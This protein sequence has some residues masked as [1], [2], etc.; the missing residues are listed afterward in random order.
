MHSDAPA[1]SALFLDV[2]L[3][4]LATYLRM[5]GYDTAY[6][7]DRGVED[8]D[9]ILEL[10]RG[11]GR[12]LVTRDEELAARR[13]DSVLLRSLDVTDQLCELRNCDFDLSLSDPVRC[14]D[15][16]GQLVR[17]DGES[18]E[19]APD[20]EQV[21]RCEDCKKRFWKGSHWESVERTLEKL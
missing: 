16:N 5:C 3:G 14:S 10:A 21:W 7:L 2:M 11:E 6:A 12:T 4:K 19:Y 8:D 13:Q 18:P 9:R 20:D 17:D 1:R 15:C